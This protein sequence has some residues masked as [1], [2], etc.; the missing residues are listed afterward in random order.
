MN[1]LVLI[2]IAGLGAA[3]LFWDNLKSIWG[4]FSNGDNPPHK[5]MSRVINFFEK[6]DHKPGL[7]SAMNTGKFIY[8]ALTLGH[9]E[10]KNEN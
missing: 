5:E 3:V 1:N 4:N 9:K 2:G 6:Y 10:K 7:D 8:D